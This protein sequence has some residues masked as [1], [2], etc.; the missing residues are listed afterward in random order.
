MDNM[1][2]E[3]GRE[4]L[5]EAVALIEKPEHFTRQGVPRNEAGKE[6]EWHSEG[7]VRY[8]PVSAIRKAAGG[9]QVTVEAAL[10]LV[11]E[12]IGKSDQHLWTLHELG[13]HRG[14]AA[15][16]AAMQA[17]IKGEAYVQPGKPRRKG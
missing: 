1:F 6:V 4:A 8:D 7:A 13:M 12:A 9:D 14:H 16:L 5:R 2:S 3:Q 10:H 15:A 17:A 11:Q